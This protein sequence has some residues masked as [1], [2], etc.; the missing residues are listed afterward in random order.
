M[1]VLNTLSQLGIIALLCHHSNDCENKKDDM[2][3][4]AKSA[5]LSNDEKDT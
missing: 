4:I 3:G 1:T 2:Y 5:K